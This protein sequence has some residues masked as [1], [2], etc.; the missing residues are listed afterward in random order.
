MFWLHCASAKLLLIWNVWYS[1]SQTTTYMKFLVRVFTNNYLSDV[2][3]QLLIWNV[4][5]LYSLTTTYLM[6][7]N[8]YLSEMFGTGFHKHNVNPH[9]RE[10]AIVQQVLSAYVMFN[11][12]QRHIAIFMGPSKL[13]IFHLPR[14][15]YEYEYG[16]RLFLLIGPGGAYQYQICR[17]KTM[18]VRW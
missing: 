7:T 16:S 5:Y 3:K 9:W 6:F 12:W 8:N 11:S 14:Y 13:H 1:Y 10:V 15:V 4:W 17:V 2:H 18:L